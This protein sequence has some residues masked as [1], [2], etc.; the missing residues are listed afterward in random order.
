M[1]KIL[2]LTQHAATAEQ[3]AA[4]VVEP[5]DKIVVQA[6]LTFE[7]LPTAGEIKRRA[8]SLSEFAATSGCKTAMIGG[9]PFFMGP[10]EYALA[11]AGIKA[12]YAFSRRETVEEKLP[13]GGVKKTQV[14]RHAG[15]V[16]TF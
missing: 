1:E 2:N 12:L 7:E 15:F 3:I 16:S 10:L 9:A 6:L 11:T 4:G 13:D 8:R 14:F 5:A